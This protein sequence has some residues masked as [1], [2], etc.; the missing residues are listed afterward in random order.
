MQRA[1]VV[2]IP[3][4]LREGFCLVACEA[5]ATQ[6][7]VVGFAGPGLSESIANCETGL[8]VPQRS[9][10]ALADAITTL[11][12]NQSLAACMGAAGRRRIEQHFNLKR[13]TALLEAKYDEILGVAAPATQPAEAH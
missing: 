1:A 13:Q 9:T 5:Q 6:V 2:A 7:P 11:L 12:T 10:G 3:S 8:L 4:D